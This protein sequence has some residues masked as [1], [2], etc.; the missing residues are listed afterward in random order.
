MKPLAIVL[1]ILQG[2]KEVF[3]GVSLVLPLLTKLNDQLNQRVYSFLGPIRDWV[4]N[5]IDQR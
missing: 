2:E 1:D 3:L 5:K 4:V